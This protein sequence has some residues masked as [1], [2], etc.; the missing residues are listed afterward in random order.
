[1][2]LRVDSALGGDLHTSSLAAAAFSVP[3]GYSSSLGTF[4]TRTLLKEKTETSTHGFCS[5]G[6]QTHM[7]REDG[8]G[9]SGAL[10]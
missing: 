10:H 2:P 9:P 4:K 1:M 5:R 3:R 8:H 7:G 6:K